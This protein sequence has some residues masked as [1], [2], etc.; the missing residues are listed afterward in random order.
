VV[1]IMREESLRLRSSRPWRTW[2]MLRAIVGI[3]TCMKYR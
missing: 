3:G 2:K 1:F